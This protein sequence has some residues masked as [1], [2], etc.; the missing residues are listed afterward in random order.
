MTL[1]I[2][3]KFT[4]SKS[5]GPDST[6]VRPS[7]WN[8]THDI[9][10]AGNKLVGRAFGPDGAA[11]EIAISASLS[12]VGGVLDFSSAVVF[13][14]TGA[15]T[16]PIGT[17]AQRPSSP[18]N[19][20]MRYNSTL[21]ACEKYEAGTW[22]PLYALPTNT[23]ITNLTVTGNALFT[24]NHGMQLPSGTTAQRDASP[25]EG[26]IRY[27]S[28]VP[29][30]ETFVSGQ[31]Q[32]LRNTV[33]S[34]KRQTVLD[35]PADTTGPT[36]FPGSSASLVL[37]SQN[38][39]ASNPLVVSGAM[40]SGSAGEID[41]IGY[42]ESNVVWPAAPAAV[43]ITSATISG[44]TATITTSSAHGLA[45][46]AIVVISG[47]T[48]TN[49]NGTYTIT[50]TSPTTFTY[51]PTTT[52]AGN[53]TV[54]GSYT[55][56]V[57]FGVTIGATGVMTPF[58]LAVPASYVDGAAPNTVLNQYTFDYAHYDMYKGNGATADIVVAVILGEAQAGMVA[59]SGVVCY[60]YRGKIRK[61]F[62]PVL[63][64]Q[65]VAQFNHNIGVTQLRANIWVQCVTA[66][67]GY[68]PGDVSVFAIAASA[69]NVVITGPVSIRDRLI[70][71][72][73]RTNAGIFVAEGTGSNWQSITTA[74][75]LYLIDCERAW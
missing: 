40:G 49:Y 25:A 7:N 58:V 8:D 3:H 11:T 65:G 13:P 68:K 69:T 18:A 72:T 63:T 24:N 56:T 2:K 32:Q 30:V 53:A 26:I 1:T 48:S 42:S 39:S 36:L 62:G 47:M 74:D 37:T 16:L 28:D 50:V 9:Q 5:D 60:Q 35:G 67:A 12:L 19:G 45:T 55:V 70:G 75:W 31:W 17:T 52:P 71:M 4:S 21:G 44:G 66:D 29:C 22:G 15:I 73:N 14:G 23:T 20:M 57:F 6:F 41:L 59:L 34:S 54:V 10:M 43:G 51:V 38:V 33:K 46:G 27:N 64:G 61:T